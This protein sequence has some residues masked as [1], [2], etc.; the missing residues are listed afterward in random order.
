MNESRKSALA[1]ARLCIDAEIQRI[2]AEIQILTD[3]SV[4][5]PTIFGPVQALRDQVRR[6]K[7]HIQTIVR[8]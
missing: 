4:N 8:E 7:E 3:I 1:Y 2:E 6:L 5:V